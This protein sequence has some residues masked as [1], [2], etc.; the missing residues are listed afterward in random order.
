MNENEPDNYDLSHF[1]TPRIYR[2]PLHLTNQGWTML[3]WT[4][5]AVAI[6]LALASGWLIAWLIY[7]VN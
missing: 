2:G 6:A 1:T 7:R 3:E 4:L 5:T